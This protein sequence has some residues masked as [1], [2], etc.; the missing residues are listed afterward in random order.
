VPW[1]WFESIVTGVEFVT[2]SLFSTEAAG[3]HIRS[4]IIVKK[5]SF[6]CEKKEKKRNSR[7]A[8]FQH[9]LWI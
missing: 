5:D 1:K 6:L 7:T 2:N 4:K 9:D 8:K 3:E